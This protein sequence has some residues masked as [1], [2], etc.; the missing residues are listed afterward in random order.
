MVD[1][2]QV[3]VHEEFEVTN[4]VDS[5]SNPQLSKSSGHG[6]SKW[7]PYQRISAYPNPVNYAYSLGRSTLADDQ[8]LRRDS[9]SSN[10]GT[11]TS[12]GSL[13]PPNIEPLNSQLLANT[14]SSTGSE[15]GHTTQ[16]FDAWGRPATATHE[17]VNQHSFPLHTNDYGYSHVD[18]QPLQQSHYPE[19]EPSYH[20][21]YDEEEKELIEVEDKVFSKTVVATKALKV[22]KFIF[23][24]FMVLV[25]LLLAGLA[26]LGVSLSPAILPLALFPLGV[27]ALLLFIPLFIIFVPIVAAGFGGGKKRRRRSVVFNNFEREVDKYLIILQVS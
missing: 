13:K 8:L 14:Y 21:H 24:F 22:G 2:H 5:S 23:T 7:S 12:L 3:R 10:P 27:I 20:H 4:N 18:L 19:P 17:A 11:D 26:K 25:V 16:M 6:T 9:G 15:I 1:K